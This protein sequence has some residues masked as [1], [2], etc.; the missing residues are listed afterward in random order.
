V[1][2]IPDNFCFIPWTG[3]YVSRDTSGPC[4]VNY[5]LHNNSD[6]NSY[7]ESKELEDLKKS[8]IKGEK[9]SSCNACWKEEELGLSSVRKR[10][11][12]E[13]KHY[14][15]FTIRVSNKCNF[16]CRMCHPKHSSAWELDKEATKLKDP[17]TEEPFTLDTFEKNVN[18]ILNIAKNNK[19]TI[20]IRGGEP[21]ISDEFLHFLDRCS[22]LNVYNNITM[23]INSNLS[24]STYK[25]IDYKK[26]FD[27]FHRVV[28]NASIDGINKV[29]EYIRRGFKQSIFDKNLEYFKKFIETL[30]ITVQVYNVYDIPNIYNYA[31]DNNIIVLLNYLHRPNYL[32]VSIL[33]KKERENILNYYSSLN[34]T[35][36]EI[37][38]ILKK[39][40]FKENE[41]KRFIE[42]TK[43]LDKL[44]KTDFIKSIPEL[45]DWYNRL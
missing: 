25:K 27:K 1:K 4:C 7:L 8:F 10:N 35:N 43:G 24:V 26:E 23:F 2:K 5:K 14:Y 6:I 21:L 16:T 33:D 13:Y 41:L 45:K 28:I 30:N 31:K 3:V 29:G 15:Y 17:Y 40:S 19:V 11:P 22:I 39:E 32:S 37:I 38:N 44:W 9:H 18:F 34:F 12:I 20:V 42:Y 36:E